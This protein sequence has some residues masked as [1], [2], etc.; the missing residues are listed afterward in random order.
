MKN[1]IIV[2]LILLV[3]FTF[4]AFTGIAQE[5]RIIIAVI[6]KADWCPVC[7]SNGEKMMK[8]VMPVF[9]QSVIQFV[10]NDLTNETT[11][12]DSKV[13]LNEV[14]VFDA[15]KK[16]NATGLLIL[17]DVATGKVLEKISVAEPVEK[18]IMTIR[19]K[20]MIEKK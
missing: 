11:K 5:G 9:E 2:P 10:M 13:K 7:Q 19:Q 4:S 17:V 3:A 6:N 15:V 14:K 16:I 1:K 18:L 8:E 20:A 12:T